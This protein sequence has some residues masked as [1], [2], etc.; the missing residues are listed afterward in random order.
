MAA[1]EDH[2]TEG[3]PSSI[4]WFMVKSM[5]A[6]HVLNEVREIVELEYARILQEDTDG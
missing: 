5:R 4:R 2:P 6:V 3:Q 1:E